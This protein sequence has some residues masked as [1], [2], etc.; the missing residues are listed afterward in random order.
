[1]PARRLDRSV[2]LWFAVHDA[3]C[4]SWSGEEGRTRESDD[5]G[6]HVPKCQQTVEGDDPFCPR[7]GTRLLK[8]SVYE[9][10]ALSTD[11]LV[12]QRVAGRY[13]VIRRLGEDGMG[14]VFLAEHEDIE[15]RLAFKVLKHEYSSRP[16]MV[17]RCKQEAVSASR[18]KHPNMVEVF[19][20]DQVDDGRFYLAME[21]PEGTDLADVLAA[22]TVVQPR[23]AVR[24]A[25]R[26][27]RALAAAHAKGVV[28]RDMKP[29]NVFLTRTA[30]GEEIVKVVDFGL[31]RSGIW[32]P[33]RASSAV[34]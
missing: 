3:R 20:F 17:V 21:P 9:Q 31:R 12:G 7:D 19:D 5:D 34:A 16:D 15:K 22:E 27:C 8:R 25:L 13:L 24:I 32:G 30:D 11:A 33:A 10:V 29:E 14:D 4:E 26:V 23:R 2:G 18:I 1:V 28:Q 6:S